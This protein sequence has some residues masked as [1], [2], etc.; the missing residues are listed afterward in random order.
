MT[1]EGMQVEPNQHR[2][3]QLA[4]EFDVDQCFRR[5]K[6]VSQV[7]SLPHLVELPLRPSQAGNPKNYNR[8]NQVRKEI[9]RA[10]DSSS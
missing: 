7:R 4:P 9:F 6:G 5:F 10:T 2:A 8:R 1:G 3:A